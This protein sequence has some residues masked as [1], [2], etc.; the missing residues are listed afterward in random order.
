MSAY[1]DIKKA[2]K[3]LKP[4]QRAV[5]DQICVGNDGGHH[6]RT[7]DLLFRKGL[8]EWYDEDLGGRPPMTVKRYVVPIPIHMAWCEVCS[9]DAGDE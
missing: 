8:V 3:L 9:E 7:L 1:D 5:F 6:P 4:G 2:I